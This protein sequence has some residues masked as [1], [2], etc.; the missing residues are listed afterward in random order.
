M[1]LNNMWLMAESV[2]EAAGKAYKEAR[3]GPQF[4]R[5]R[6]MQ[7]DFLGTAKE[8]VPRVEQFIDAG[9]GYFICKVEGPNADVPSQME[10][11][12]REILPQF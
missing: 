2:D 10:H 4:N 7:Y 9:C 5:E 6:A 3:Y 8:I 12:T 11:L 1:G